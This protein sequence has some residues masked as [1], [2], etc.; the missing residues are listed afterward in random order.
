MQFP[1]EPTIF[2]TL[3]EEVLNR[4]SLFTLVTPTFSLCSQEA[5]SG[6]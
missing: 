5:S 1:R 6:I 4:I 3:E 2:S